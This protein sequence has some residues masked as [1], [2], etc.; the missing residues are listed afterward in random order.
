MS[1]ETCPKLSAEQMAEKVQKMILQ[2]RHVL[3][4]VE[5]VAVTVKAEPVEQIKEEKGSDS[6]QPGM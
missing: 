2:I 1:R 4:E 6:E 5:S 3:K